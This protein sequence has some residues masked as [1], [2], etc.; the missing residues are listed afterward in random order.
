MRN[1]IWRDGSHIISP[2]LTHTIDLKRGPPLG[3]QTGEGGQS[4]EDIGGP[5]E[6]ERVTMIEIA[7]AASQGPNRRG[8]SP[9][10]PREKDRKLPNSKAGRSSTDE[11]AA[12]HAYQASVDA[13]VRAIPGLHAFGAYKAGKH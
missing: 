5:P 9:V 4:T 1:H 12:F 3:H 10:L 11:R 6:K 7:N 2:P 8:R 13:A